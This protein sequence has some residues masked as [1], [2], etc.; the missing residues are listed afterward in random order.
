MFRRRSKVPPSR[1]RGPDGTTNIRASAL[2]AAR[3]EVST[4]KKLTETAMELEQINKSYI[5]KSITLQDVNLIAIKKINTKIKNIISN[6]VGGAETHNTLRC[7]IY[8]I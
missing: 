8:C 7:G 4:S 3:L 6:P 2:E 1:S 5:E